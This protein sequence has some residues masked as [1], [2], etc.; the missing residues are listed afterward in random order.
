M[1]RVLLLTTM[2]LLGGFI[3]SQ[4]DEVLDELYKD[5]LAQKEYTI[6][7]VLQAAG[8]LDNTAEVSD[9]VTELEKLDW[10]EGILKD[11]KYISYGS[12]SLL[13][14]EAFKLPHGI[15]YGLIQNKRYALREM[16]YSGYIL[17]NSYTSDIITSFDVVYVLS[18]LPVS[19]DVSNKWVES[20]TPAGTEA[21][22]ETEGEMK[23]AEDAPVDVTTEEVITETAVSEVAVEPANTETVESEVAAEPVTTEIT[24]P[25]AATEPAAD[26]ATQEAP[27]EQ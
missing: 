4:S 2:L 9:A 5:E 27:V 10:G 20:E 16:K 6:L 14:M 22:V 11:D 25:D 13:V 12:F 23:V 24:Q 26:G 3:F 21:V 19:E 8:I 7:L 15:M 18:S 17:G 1:K